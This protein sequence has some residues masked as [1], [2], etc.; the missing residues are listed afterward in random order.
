MSRSQHNIIW[1][2]NEFYEYMMTIN[3]SMY[4]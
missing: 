1:L 3:V 4:G 2:R